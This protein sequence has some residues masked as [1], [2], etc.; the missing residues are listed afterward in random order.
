MTRRFPALVLA[1]VLGAIL[2]AAAATVPSFAP[3]GSGPRYADTSNGTTTEVPSLEAFYMGD[4]ELELDGV[5]DDPV[6]D[7]AQTGWGFRQAEPDRWTEASV[8]SVFK[9]LYDDDAIY[10]GMACYEDDV[11]DISSYLSRRDQIQASDIVSIYIDPYHDRTTGYNFRVNP[12]GVQ[13]DAYLYDNGNRDEDWNAVWEAE[14]HHDAQGWYV[15]I[16]IPFSA[17]RFKPEDDMTWGLQAYRWLHGRGEDT[18]W[19]L[20]DRNASGF[21][22]R[23]GTLTGLRG[24]AN[25]RKLEVLPYFVTKHVDPAADGDG[26]QWQNSQNFGADFKYGL[27]SN[28]TL[29]ATFQPDFGQ[30][31]ADPATL[32]L[33][34]FE[35]F[36]QEKRP[37]FVE[38]ARYFQ[39]PDFNLFYSRRIGT[40]DPNARIRGAAKL[41]GKMGSG[42][43]LAV[44]GAATDV[45]QEGKT[46]NPFAGGDRKAYYGLVRVG[47]EFDEGNH[48]FNVMGTAVRRDDE[49]FAAVDDP[50]YR[51]DGYSGGFDFMMNFDDRNWRLSG[52]GVGTVVDPVLDPIDPTV[53]TGKRYGTGG[54]FDFRRA[55]GDLRGGIGV[56]WEHDL[57]DPNDMGFLSAPDEKVLHGHTAWLYDSDG[58]DKAFNR[59]ELYLEGS[60]STFYAGDTGYDVETGE[61]V[62]EYDGDHHQHTSVSLNAWGQLKNFQQGWIWIGHRFEGTSKYATRLYYDPFDPPQNT[63]NGNEQYV[64]YRG[65]LMTSPAW[66]G[67]SFGVDSDWRKP[68]QIGVDFGWDGNV[69]GSR[70]GEYE[71]NVRWNQSEHFSHQLGFEFSTNDEDAQ[72]MANFANDGSQ[73]GVAGIGGIDHVFGRLDQET[74]E[75]VLRSNILFDRDQSLQ[76]YVAPFHTYGSYSNPRWLATPD[77]YDLRPYDLEASRYD[78]N[79]GQVNINLVY[80][81][82]YRS[83]STL[84]LVWTH[85]KVRYDERGD[86]NGEDWQSGW[87]PGFAF[88]AEPENTFLAKLS[89]WFSI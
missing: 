82:E 19:V 30:V 86:R 89:Y 42:F 33:S 35:T 23:W 49:T 43:N 56:R 34:P 12:A 13:Q 41:T 32:N 5:L 60:T 62:W 45:A 77:S 54:D 88:D 85:G 65:P 44:L 69:E 15:E 38:G 63:E 87:D 72:W 31:E 74:F 17:I 9:V 80:R 67:L 6:W 68:L 18:A 25:P 51:R 55:G 14:V 4:M 7:L 46:H 83:G 78:F 8:P 16:R 20:W 29:N 22:S 81:W 47:R 37:F 57:L 50:R 1:C 39:H 70:H 11:A 66:S 2:P 64:R 10:F 48:A 75:L 28:L 84:Y 21:V 59:A 58:E 3:T 73:A 24:V 79:Y 27:T 40:G 52:S 76:I 71:I 26:D 61:K 53:P 36:Y